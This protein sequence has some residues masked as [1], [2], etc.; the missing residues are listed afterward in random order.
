M[1]VIDEIAAFDYRK[2]STYFRSRKWRHRGAPIV[3]S[4]DGPSS[5]LAGFRHGVIAVARRLSPR[6]VPGA[7]RRGGLAARHF[8]CWL[9]HFG[10]RDDVTNAVFIDW[11]QAIYLFRCLHCGRLRMHLPP[12]VKRVR[13]GGGFFLGIE[14]GLVWFNDAT[15]DVRSAMALPIADATAANIRRR[16]TQKRAESLAVGR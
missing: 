2:V 8:F 14:S 6:P 1:T 12:V 13:K 10:H 16:I 5:R 4:P 15:G 3:R 9:R 7:K 11:K